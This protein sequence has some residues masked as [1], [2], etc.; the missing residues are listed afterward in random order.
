[1]I[2]QEKRKHSRTDSLRLLNYVSYDD[3]QVETSQ[4][5][6]RTLNVSETGIM[7]E[8]HVP[9]PVKTIASIKIGFEENVV[10]VLGRVI[11][12]NCNERGRYESG[13]DFFE[14]DAKGLEIIRQYTVAFNALSD[15][16]RHHQ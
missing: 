10:D 5:M 7:L 12:S 11:Y 1:M 3:N 13:I 8:T 6:G 16:D 15:K 2:L 4:G 14:V 9:I